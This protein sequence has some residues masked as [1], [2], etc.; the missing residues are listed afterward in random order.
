MEGKEDKELGAALD[1]AAGQEIIQ[2]AAWITANRKKWF[3]WIAAVITAVSGIVTTLSY[4]SSA[5][6]KLT[7]FSGK[8]SVLCR[9]VSTLTEAQKKHDDEWNEHRKE[10]RQD[11]QR[12]EDKLDENNSKLTKIE[13]IL[14]GRS[15]PEPRQPLK[16]SYKCNER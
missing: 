3:A 5:L 15:N 9:D 13:T 14:S 12:L 16:I 6:Q 10:N 11:I 4:S 8:I 1:T 7:D 2:A